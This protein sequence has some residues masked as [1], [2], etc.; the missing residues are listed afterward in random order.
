MTPD[1]ARYARQVATPGVGPEGQRKLAG[2]RV[3]L[4][5]AGGLGSPA[6][7][8]LAGAGVG[9]LTLV[10]DDRVEVS[11]LHRQ[12]VHT[13]SRTGE[14][15][16]DSARAAL[17]DLNPEVEVRT[18]RDRVTRDN[19][20]DLLSGHDLVLDGCDDFATRYVVSD[21][22]TVLGIPHVWASVLA[23]GGQLS[24]FDP[25][26]GPVYRDVFPSAPPAGSVPSCAQAGVIGTVPGILGTAMAAEALKIILG[27][28][29]PL[30]GTLAVYDMLTAEWDRVPVARNPRVARPTTPDDIG[31]DIHQPD[32]VEA[33]AAALGTAL[34]VDVREPEEFAAGAVP[35]SVNVPVATVEADPAAVHAAAG[36]RPVWVYCRTGVRSARAAE[37]LRTVAPALSGPET[38]DSTIHDT[39]GGWEAWVRRIGREY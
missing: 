35:G 16:V 21:A 18:V 27:I 39:A 9:T 8:F 10:D 23:T 7:L 11:N 29:H 4:V 1:P 25:D 5:G 15:K 2:A 36:S 31:R 32:P 34:V 6:A 28:G 33:L 3:L 24:V 19:A 22:T 17:D 13:T 30:V 38:H 37:A 26:R 12:V 14:Y 20:L